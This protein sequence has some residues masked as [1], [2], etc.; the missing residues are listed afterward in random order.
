MR[1][2]LL[3]SF[4]ISF[5]IEYVSSPNRRGSGIIILFTASK[6]E[7]LLFLYPIVKCSF[8]YDINI[9]NRVNKTGLQP[10]S[11]TCGTGSLFWR[12][13]S[14]NLHELSS[15]THTIKHLWCFLNTLENRICLCVVNGLN[16][17]I[18]LNNQNKCSR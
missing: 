14:S 8:L 6:S 7:I 1:Q 2:L 18:E 15:I 5:F 13:S 3:F 17:Y 9:E 11:M 10:V 16:K 12:V 4:S